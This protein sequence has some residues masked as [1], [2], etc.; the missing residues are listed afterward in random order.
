MVFDE[1][2]IPFPWLVVSYLAVSDNSAI[3]SNGGFTLYA[4]PSE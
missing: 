4:F 3:H 2:F 1:T